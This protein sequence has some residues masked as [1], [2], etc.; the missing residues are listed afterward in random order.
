[1]KAI[2]ILALA[3]AAAGFATLG[4]CKSNDS[5]SSYTPPPANPGGTYIDSGK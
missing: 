2:R 4:A 5:G 3:L 1:M